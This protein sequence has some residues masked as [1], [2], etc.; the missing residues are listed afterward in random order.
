MEEYLRSRVPWSTEPS[1]KEKTDELGIDFDRFIHGLKYNKPDIEMAG[2]F[3]VSEN[4]IR[5][6]RE[7]FERKGLGSIMGQD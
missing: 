2:E 6:L 7:H 1:L 4:A 5:H 3:G